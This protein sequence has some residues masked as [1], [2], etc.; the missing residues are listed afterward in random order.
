MTTVPRILQAGSTGMVLPMMSPNGANPNVSGLNA[1]RD[2]SVC[3][4]G[5]CRPLKQPA[6]DSPT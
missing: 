6:A 3:S 1:S 4:R 5:Q 2:G